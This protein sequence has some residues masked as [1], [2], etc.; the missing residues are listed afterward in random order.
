[1][2]FLTGLFILLLVIASAH[3]AAQ[4]TTDNVV[5]NTD[6]NKFNAND[7]TR[8]RESAT[9]TVQNT[10]AE[11]ITVKTTITGLPQDYSFENISDV[12]VAGN[13][14]TDISF[15]INI[16]HKES[17]GDRAIGTI[18]IRDANNVE[19]DHATITQRTKPMLELTDVKAEYVNEKGESQSDDFDRDDEL[20]LKEGAKPGTEVKLM[21]K[22]KNLFDRNYDDDFNAL[23]DIELTL[24][25]QD[26]DLFGDDV[27]T[28][29]SFEDL[30][31]NER[32]EQTITFLIADDAD[33]DDYTVELTLEGEDGKGALHKLERDIKIEVKRGRNDVRITKAQLQPEKITTCTAQFLLDVQ[34][35]NQGTK[36]Q[37]FTGL[38][39][40]NEE[41]GINENIQDIKLD[42]FSE[43]DDTF[44]RVFTFP[45]DQ[46][47]IKVKTYP[48]D[49]TSY[50]KKT[51]QIDSEKV[52]LVVEKCPTAEQ[53]KEAK[54]EQLTNQ[55]VEQPQPS[56]AGQQNAA[57]TQ[58][59]PTATTASPAAP[60]IKTIEQ[61]YSVEDILLGGIIVVGVFILAMI[62]IFFVLL[63]K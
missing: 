15:S 40:V 24:E 51:E 55:T 49:I 34:L 9:I 12:Q 61:P 14:T 56:Q 48:L 45:V 2:K 10:G 26:D 1:M 11:A 4:I 16:P 42:S 41:L 39:I 29:Y 27:D 13:G 22:I 58:P 18:S 57:A 8:I 50:I 37:D 19:L 17:S 33:P 28:T 62:V 43:S 52:N 35:R 25:P 63:I 38:T 46:K 59:T 44:E 21:F 31:A 53:P 32:G 36:Q 60:I 6:Y 47:K 30:N 23:E 3:A 20:K 7:L 5:L 54:K